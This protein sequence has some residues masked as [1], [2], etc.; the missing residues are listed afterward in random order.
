MAKK[1]KQDKQKVIYYDDNSTIAD[2]SNLPRAQS[3]CW[4]RR[5]RRW[6]WRQESTGRRCRINI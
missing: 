2:M 1:T 4:N 3:G 6:G 5:E